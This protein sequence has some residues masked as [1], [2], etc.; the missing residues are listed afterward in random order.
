M[1]YALS[2]YFQPLKFLKNLW[3]W[4]FYFFET[5][6]KYTLQISNKNAKLFFLSFR[7]FF[8]LKKWKYSIPH[9]LQFKKFFKNIIYVLLCLLKRLKSQKIMKKIYNIKLMIYYPW[10]SKLMWWVCNLLIQNLIIFI[11]IL[12]KIVILLL[13]I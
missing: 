1:K 2:Y 9:T 6:I 7:V 10:K 13:N 8:F 4:F 12:M 5:H 11:L 3:V